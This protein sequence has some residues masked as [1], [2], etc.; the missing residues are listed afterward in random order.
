MILPTIGT[1]RH[2]AYVAESVGSDNLPTDSWGAYTDVPTHGWHP[3]NPAEIDGGVGRRSET[4]E[5]VL[6][7]P[8]MVCGDR[9]RWQV[10]GDTWE[11][12]GRPGDFNHGPFGMTVPLLVYLKKV[13][14]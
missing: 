3:P 7:V 11:Q 6:M 10:A 9:D 2:G 8:V 14:G 4:C 12:M 13:E 5:L 1:V